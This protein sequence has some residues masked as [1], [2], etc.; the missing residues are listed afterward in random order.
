MGSIGVRL[1][2]KDGNANV[3][4]AEAGSTLSGYVYFSTN[5]EVSGSFLD[6]I[7]VGEERA[8]ITYQE[9][10]QVPKI[11]GEPG[12]MESKSFPRTVKGARNILQIPI[13]VNQQELFLD[14]Y[15][16][17]IPPGNYKLP[18]ELDLPSMLPSTMEAHGAD[19]D[20]RCSIRY[21]IKAELKG[22]GWFSNYSSRQEIHVSS[23]P[24]RKDRV[25]CF[26]EPITTPVSACCFSKG[27]MTYGAKV[28]DTILERGEQVTVKMSCVNNTSVEIES[29]H[30]MLTEIVSWTVD[31][32]TENQYRTLSRADFGT[33]QSRGQEDYVTS[34]MGESNF[35]EI[36]NDIEAGAHCGIIS[37]DSSANDT[38]SGHFIRTN[39]SIRI[40]ITTAGCCVGDPGLEIPIQCGSASHNDSTP[41]IFSSNEEP[42]IA[43]PAWVDEAGDDAVT[44]TSPIFVPNS[45]ATVGGGNAI[46][47][48][49]ENT[50]EAEINLTSVTF[51]DEQ[52]QHNVDVDESS[53]PSLTKLLDEL[54]MSVSDLGIIEKKSADE[55]WKTSVFS[56]LSPTDFQQVLE[57]VDIDFD[58][59]KV[60]VILAS[61]IDENFTCDY[62]VLALQAKSVANWNRTN[63]VEKL[64][65][66]CKDV[67]TNHERIRQEL[68]EWEQQLTAKAFEAALQE[69]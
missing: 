30:A 43:V 58:Q 23:K 10:K 1:T 69:E 17:Q 37:L 63:M 35:D 36:M 42:E 29:T 46:V 24:L 22:S 68:S 25:P 52:Q 14:G 34:R 19:S 57:Q 48:E 15:G 39:H 28:D 49:S 66:H 44:S 47:V 51:P 65:G 62:V 6:V 60:A 11:G 18:F 59:P 31:G 67:Q 20:S 64:I 55:R 27:S 21:Y 13:P 54:K 50:D 38:Y 3:F 56:N 7:V 61:M 2:T 33:F 45:Y 26:K 12:E 8:Q 53:D 41:P 40:G 9:V 32:R 16:Q 4:G 5:K